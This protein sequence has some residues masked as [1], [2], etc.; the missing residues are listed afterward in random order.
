M[1]LRVT[2]VLADFTFDDARFTLPFDFL[3]VRDAFLTLR[4]EVF[5][6]EATPDFRAFFSVRLALVNLPRALLFCRLERKEVN[7]LQR[8]LRLEVAT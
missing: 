1:Q 6:L 7:L 2:A 4:F 5:T 8:A 3:K